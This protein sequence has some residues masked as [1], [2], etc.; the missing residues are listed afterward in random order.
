MSSNAPE[1]EPP[2]VLNM[3]EDGK[4][5]NCGSEDKTETVSC[6]FC[7]KEF[8]LFDCF[9]DSDDDIV[10]S[11]CGKSFYKAIN[12]TGKYS[13]RPGNFRF[14]CDPCLTNFENEQTCTSNDR[15]QMLDNRVSNLA[16]DVTV[17]KEMLKEMSTRNA[18][19][20]LPTSS[21]TVPTASVSDTE[22]N[23]N[24]VNLWQD[25]T[26]VKSLLVVNKEF[27]LQSKALEK[28]VTSSGIQINGQYVNKKGDQVFILPSQDARTKLKDELTTTGVPVQHITEPKQRYPAISVV[29]IP[30]HFD[31]N[32]KDSLVEVLLNQNPNISSLVKADNSMFEVLAVKTVRSNSN[33]NQAIIRLSDNIRY[34]IKNMGN[35]LFCGM[36]SCK[37]YDQLYIKR[38]NRCQEFGH[39]AKECTG[40]VCCGICASS[41][42]ESTA[43]QYSGNAQE[44]NLLCCINCKKSGLNDHMKTHQANSMNCPAYKAKQEKLKSSLSYYSSSK[45]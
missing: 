4:C 5:M 33:I 32:S 21:T 17:I 18:G 45:N 37:V 35:K 2:S 27:K 39:Y 36:S 30:T 3:L 43:C 26:K 23:S 11:S 9:E 42:H 28:S 14:V 10:T 38:C 20:E 29:G 31:K 34:A 40:S 44:L 25:E 24:V 8:H 1:G 41:E 13:Y 16:G 22:V 19:E 12:K 7:K 15:V 6:L